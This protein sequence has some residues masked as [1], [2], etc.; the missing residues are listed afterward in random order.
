MF[1]VPAFSE[2]SS[3]W[4]A[5]HTAGQPENTSD[6]AKLGLSTCDYGCQWLEQWT[7]CG[8]AEKLPAEDRQ[9]PK[10]KVLGTLFQ[11]MRT[12][13]KL[14]RV[15]TVWNVVSLHSLLGVRGGLAVTRAPVQA[16]SPSDRLELFSPEADPGSSSQTL[17]TSSE[18]HWIPTFYINA[19]IDKQLL[20]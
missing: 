14:A 13:E 8:A 3:S 20:M 6:R 19:K 2:T 18:F 5:G 16:K 15:V 10:E 7:A 17:N 11:S 9:D 4:I 12:G 1:Q